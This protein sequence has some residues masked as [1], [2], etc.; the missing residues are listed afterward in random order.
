MKALLFSGLLFLLSL[1][2]AAH[3]RNLSNTFGS[4]LL[5]KCKTAIKMEDVSPRLTEDER[6]MVMGCVAY[7]QGAMDADAVWFESE[8]RRARTTITAN[9]CVPD[10][11]K[12]PQIIRILVKWLE[13]IQR[14]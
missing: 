13:T 1:T 6:F 10:D 12:W 11:V 5:K 14:N 2:P 4:D 8:S 9:Y 7:V 3:A